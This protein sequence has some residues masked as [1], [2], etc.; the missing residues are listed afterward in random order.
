MEGRATDPGEHIK[1]LEEAQSPL[2]AGFQ[3]RPPGFHRGPSLKD[4][5]VESGPRLREDRF[6]GHNQGHL[7][8]YAQP[9]GRVACGGVSV[10]G[11]LHEPER[12]QRIEQRG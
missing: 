1:R 8:I 3:L 12:H 5:L 4:D 6:L 2:W 10:R 9:T 11:G 7:T